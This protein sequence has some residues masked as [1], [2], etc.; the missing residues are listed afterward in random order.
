MTTQEVKRKLAAILSADAKG[1]S[2]LMGEDEE[3]TIRTLNTYKEAM[4]N[5]IQ[6]QRGR[7][8]DAPGDNVLAE[9][10]SVVDAVRCAVDIQ[11]EFKNRNAQ[12]PESRR[13]E[14]RIGVNLGDVVEEE[15]KIFGDG[16]NIAARM[17][18]LSEAGG[19]CIS[20]SAYD[21]VGK[22]LSLGYEYLGEHTVK[23]IEKP[24]R[25]YRVLME[26]EAAGEVIGEKKAKSKQWQRV[27]IGLVVAVIMVVAA[28]VIWRLYLHPAPPPAEVAS[29][30][31]MAFPLPD[32]P[33]IAVLPFANISGEKDLEYFSDGLAE[34]IINGLSK[35]DRI[36]VIARNSTFTYKGKPVK[37]KQVAEEMGVR[38]VIE[39]SVQQE[40]NRVRI[41][42]QLI[43]ALT[44]RH[45]F[46]ERYDRDLKNILNLQDEITMEVMTAVQVKLTT[47]EA[48]R[49][50]EK[51]TKNLDAYLKVL[52]AREYKA[53]TFN[54][55]RAERGRQLLEEAIALDPEYAWAYS[56]LSTYYADLVV[57]GASESPR[58]SLQRAIDLGKKAIALDDSN[59]SVHANMTFPYIYLREFDKAISEAEKAISLNPNLAVG[60]WALGTA[61]S[62][63]GRAQE[64]IPMLQKSLRLSPIPIHSNVLSILAN[65][66]AMLGRYEEAIDTHKKVLQIYG[67]D[68]LMA[69]I[70][71][72][73]TY[74][75]MGRENEARAEGAEVLRIDP[76]FSWE[77]WIKSLP[78]DQS[79]KDRMADA[80]RKAGLK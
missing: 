9:F 14:F 1:Y 64:S 30:E 66:Y 75:V 6:Q 59:S 10:G 40:R 8:V 29:K 71:L 53:G 17:E 38:Y 42:V 77:R 28:V 15:G 11:K 52:Q 18:S 46:S 54:K 44:G 47:G 67:P 34:G 80:L 74:A 2:R 50:H 49:L 60:Y 73:V 25:V 72:A 63:S 45:L 33:S 20:G 23:N 36:L 27:T 55:E 58:E 61:L 22:K 51:G 70:S 69:H 12:L 32:K 19:V 68:H 31:K 24:V 78:Y 35:S 26:P 79:R 13:M 39:G 56:L 65:S 57:L 62:L 7:V 48:A 21:F 3:G 5:L 76:K 37:V 4:L 41:T 43:D 16:V